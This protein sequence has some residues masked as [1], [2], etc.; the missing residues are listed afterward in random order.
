[1]RRL[2]S[3]KSNLFYT[4]TAVAALLLT[5]PEVEAGKKRPKATHVSGVKIDT[6]IAKEFSDP[7]A[8]C[9]FFRQSGEIQQPHIEAQISRL[10]GTLMGKSQDILASAKAE[11]RQSLLALMETADAQVLAITDR[12]PE[13]QNTL[14]AKLVTI[15]RHEK[16]FIKAGKD[17]VQPYMNDILAAMKERLQPAFAMHILLRD[18]IWSISQNA[19]RA[20]RRHLRTQQEA[21]AG[22]IN[23]IMDQLITALKRRQNAQNLLQNLDLIFS[24]ETHIAY[25]TSTQKSLLDALGTVALIDQNIQDH[26]TQLKACKPTQQLEKPEF[27]EE[28]RTWLATNTWPGAPNSKQTPKPAF[29]KAQEMWLNEQAWLDLQDTW[30]NSI[31]GT[32]GDVLPL[33]DEAHN[34]HIL[35]AGYLAKGMRAIWDTDRAL[36]TA[37]TENMLSGAGIRLDTLPLDEVKNTLAKIRQVKLEQWG[38]FLQRKPD[39]P[40]PSRAMGLMVNMGISAC[41]IHQLLEKPWDKIN[42]T[43]LRLAVAHTSQGLQKMHREMDKRNIDLSEDLT[44]LLPIYGESVQDRLEALVPLAGHPALDQTVIT[45]F[46]GIVLEEAIYADLL[47]YRPL[48]HRF[49][50]EVTTESKKSRYHAKNFARLLTLKEKP[51]SITFGRENIKTDAAACPVPLTL[52]EQPTKI[53]FF[54]ENIKTGA[55]AYAVFQNGLKSLELFQ[56]ALKARMA[57]LSKAPETALVPA[58]APA[59]QAAFDPSSAET[60]Q[61]PAQAASAAAAA[62][63]ATQAAFDPSSAETTQAPT[64]AAAAAAAVATEPP[65][66]LPQLDRG[67]KH[68]QEQ[69][70]WCREEVEKTRARIESLEEQAARLHAEGVEIPNK[71]YAAQEAAHLLLDNQEKDLQRALINLIIFQRQ[72]RT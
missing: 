55:E 9:A 45:T 31:P 6:N 5:T 35:L 30:F 21:L 38:E 70:D 1:M 14:K 44:D 26:I 34:S 57:E 66:I 47:L 46:L 25:C 62:G 68:L 52:K 64:Q 42:K 48:G 13:L 12:L 17:V 16:N 3:F 4:A 69:A 32:L 65:A 72:K 50:I 36:F 2:L 37:V 53:T 54:G 49:A 27:S 23:P 51:I 28:Q 20:A 61:A 41:T 10:P 60:T 24:R 40:V 63:P 15:L 22:E 8:A 11:Q 67:V 29:N 39:M 58:A 18:K 43:L 7:K 19:S 56:Q 71:I 33:Y 59:A